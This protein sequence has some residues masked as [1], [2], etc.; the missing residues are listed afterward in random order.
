MRALS[1]YWQVITVPDGGYRHD[2]GAS[3]GSRSCGWS[4][5]FGTWKGAKQPPWATT[6][7]DVSV[8]VC[9]GSLGQPRSNSFDIIPGAHPGQPPVPCLWSGSLGGDP[10]CMTLPR[11]G[12]CDRSISSC[13]GLTRVSTAGSTRHRWV[14]PGK[15]IDT[16]SVRKSNVSHSGIF[17]YLCW[18][19]THLNWWCVEIGLM[20]STCT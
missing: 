11:E 20:T 3:I 13:Q 9:L 12:E 15:L 14:D 19:L 1:F 8:C 2:R 10:R 7:V 17:T 6:L 16:P 18:S 4:P 5:T